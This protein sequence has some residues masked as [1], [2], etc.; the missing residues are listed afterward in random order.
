MICNNIAKSYY[1]SGG[2]SSK[3]QEV[4]PPKI[5]RIGMSLTFYK[6]SISN[7]KFINAKS[8]GLRNG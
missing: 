7:F 3:N 5:R 4:N 6:S 8:Q 1:K 2:K